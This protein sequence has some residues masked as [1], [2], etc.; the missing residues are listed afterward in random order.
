MAPPWPFRSWK[1]LFRKRHPEI[2][3]APERGL[4][5]GD[6]LK[7]K[8]KNFDAVGLATVLRTVAAL[9]IGNSLIVPVL[10]ESEARFWWV[11]F[12]VGVG[13]TLATT[14]KFSKE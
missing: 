5:L 12:L 6:I 13:I 4:F 2:L 9:L 3:K 10:T 8:Y 14:V 7:L 1:R 11:L